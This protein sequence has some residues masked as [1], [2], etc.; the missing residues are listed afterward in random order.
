M[1]RVTATAHVIATLATI[2]VPLSSWA[3][4]TTVNKVAPSG[5]PVEIA[6]VF[7]LYPDCT[8]SLDFSLKTTQEPANGKLSLQ[9]G[10]IWLS[11]PESNPHHACDGKKI[12]GTRVLYQSNKDYVGS[13][14]VTLDTIFNDG[15]EWI[16][17]INIT[18]K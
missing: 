1:P 5:S 8:A 7:R 9:N 6:D 17:Q 10:D 3:A 11:L 14:A 13:D 4:T 15:S 12:Q 18:V 2:V 16:D